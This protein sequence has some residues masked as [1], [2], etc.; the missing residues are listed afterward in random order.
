LVGPCLTDRRIRDRQ[1]GPTPLHFRGGGRRQTRT[2]VGR[3]HQVSLATQL[4]C[5]ASRQGNAVVPGTFSCGR[6]QGPP[7][8]WLPFTWTSFTLLPPA[9]PSVFMY[10]RLL[11]GTTR[12]CH[13][14]SWRT[15]TF[16]HRTHLMRE[17]DCASLLLTRRTS[18]AQ[19]IYQQP[20]LTRGFNAHVTDL[21][22]HA[23]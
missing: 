18:M 6:A 12:F 20:V 13:L 21:S 10:S 11:A 8:H 9:L 15:A 22:G 19:R 14:T 2:T 3:Q 1:A 17:A 7:A 23:D 5:Q 16:R 4:P